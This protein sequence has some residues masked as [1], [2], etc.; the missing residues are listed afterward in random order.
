MSTGL[1]LKRVI[2]EAEKNNGKVYRC[3][4]C[5]KILYKHQQLCDNCLSP[6]DWSTIS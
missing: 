3:W 4:R 2:E 1:L 6:Q 5:N